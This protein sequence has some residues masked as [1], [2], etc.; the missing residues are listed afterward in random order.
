MNMKLKCIGGHADGDYFTVPN[1]MRKSAILKVPERLTKMAPLNLR[2][3]PEMATMNYY[4]YEIDCFHFSKD[5]KYYFLR[6]V[7]WTNKQAIMHQFDK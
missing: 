6:P 2:E 5:D 1:G 4:E 3:I 7:E